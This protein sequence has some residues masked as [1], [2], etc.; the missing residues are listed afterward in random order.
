MQFKM[1]MEFIMNKKILITVVAILIISTIASTNLKKTNQLPIVAI[2]NYGPHASLEAA[3]QGLKMQMAEEGFIEDQTVTY[4]IADVGFDPSLIP[5]MVTL[6][7]QQKPKVLVVMTTPVAQF[8]K[9]KVRDIPLIYNAIADP[10]ETGLI[11]EKDKADNNMTGSSDM[12]DLK[13]FLNFAKSILPNAK[14]IGLLYATSESNDAALVKMMNEAADEVGMSVMTVPIEQSRDVPIRILEFKDNVDFIYVGTSGPI[15]PSLP[16]IASEAKKMHI[17]VFNAEEQGVKDGL[18]LA[19]YGVNY[20]SVGR[21]AGKL[22]VS[23]LKGKKISELA[24]VS[25]K[26]SDHKGLI[27]RKKAEELGIKI[28]NNIELVE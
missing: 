7:A 12:Q 15:Q 16:V 26:T 27:N 24:P 20:E 11:K 25:P 2:A 19:S 22:V 28:P 17:P 21:N 13:A 9:G 8:A 10:K 4:K 6:L 3:I 14:T 23:V 18:A 1:Y 5:Q